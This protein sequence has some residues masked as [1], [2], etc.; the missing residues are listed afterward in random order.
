VP[1]ANVHSRAAADNGSIARSPPRYS[2]TGESLSDY[3]LI[4][5]ATLCCAIVA[6]LVLRE[7]CFLCVPAA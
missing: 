5:M 4:K 7:M 6:T 2:T 1:V 3:C